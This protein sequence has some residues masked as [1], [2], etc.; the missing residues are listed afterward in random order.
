MVSV[1]QMDYG[2][3]EGDGRRIDHLESVMRNVG[4]REDSSLRVAGTARRSDLVSRDQSHRS[5]NGPVSTKVK[6]NT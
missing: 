4:H 3:V 6:K 5:A 1:Q 2:A